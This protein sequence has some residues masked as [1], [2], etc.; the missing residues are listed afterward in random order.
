MLNSQGNVRHFDHI[1]IHFLLF[2]SPPFPL[3]RFWMLSNIL[4]LEFT[5]GSRGTL[6]FPK[7]E[8]IIDIII[9]KTLINW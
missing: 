6:T 3:R 2:D 5:T 1:D 4:A 7:D 8:P 9:S